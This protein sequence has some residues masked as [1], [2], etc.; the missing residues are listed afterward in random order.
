MSVILR[1]SLLICILFYFMIILLLLKHKALELKYTLLWLA[2]GIMMA[3]LVAFPDLLEMVIHLLGI[4]TYMYGLFVICIAFII[5]ILM[6][7]TSIVSR[8]LGKIQ[9]LAQECAM[10]ENRLRKLEGE[11]MK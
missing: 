5:C 2:A 8:Q 1:T 9:S 4:E 6:A 11:S 7:L 3:L 10:L